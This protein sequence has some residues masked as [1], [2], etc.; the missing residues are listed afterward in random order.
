[1]SCD[2]SNKIFS[3]ANNVKPNNAPETIFTSPVL[4]LQHNNLG[5]KIEHFWMLRCICFFLRVTKHS[6]AHVDCL[7]GNTNL[8]HW[9]FC[10]IISEHIKFG[11]DI[12]LDWC[13]IADF[14]DDYSISTTYWQCAQYVVFSHLSLVYFGL[15]EDFNNIVDRTNVKIFQQVFVVWFLLILSLFSEYVCNPE[16]VDD[17]VRFFPSSCVCYGMSTKKLPKILQPKREK[18]IWSSFLQRHFK[19]FQSA[20]LEVLK[21][22]VWFSQKPVGRRMGKIHQIR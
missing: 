14:A 19:L 10:R 15:V 4:W 8:N 22:K 16:L 9:Q 13:P 21:W 3:M 5:I 6:I 12:S 11:K 2:V 20:Q 7:F 17:Y 1:M 18:E